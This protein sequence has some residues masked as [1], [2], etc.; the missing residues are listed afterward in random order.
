M[1]SLLEAVDR[2]RRRQH[3]A[4]RAG[5]LGEPRRLD[6]CV[7]VDL[8]RRVLEELARGIVGDRH[9]VDHRIHALQMRRRDPAGVL[10]HHL[11]PLV[12]RQVGAAEEEAVEGAHRVARLEQHR[13]Q[14][15]ADIAAC[16]GHQHTRRTVLTHLTDPL[17]GT[18]RG[19]KCRDEMSA[20]GARDHAKGDS[21][22]DSRGCLRSL[23]DRIASASG[24]GQ[25]M[26][27][28]GSFHRIPLSLAGA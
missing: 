4:P 26:P 11:E 9:E 13:H 20:G 23:S 22:S 2:A 12:R 25:A 18:R 8:Q 14:R 24:S 28:S 27:R 21:I 19:T 7:A 1:P 17:S 5:R 6:A 3:V 16:A 15:A 10:D